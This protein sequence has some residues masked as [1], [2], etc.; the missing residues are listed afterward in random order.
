MC[1]DGFL[2]VV[3]VS[4]ARKIIVWYTHTH[5]SVADRTRHLGCVDDIAIRKSA[6]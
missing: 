5:T 1:V 4:L 2:C 3:S 6:Q